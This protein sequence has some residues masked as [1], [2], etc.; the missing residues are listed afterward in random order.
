VR[1]RDELINGR[2]RGAI[3]GRGTDTGE[4]VVEPSEALSLGEESG[5]MVE[6]AVQNAVAACVAE[7][8]EV[9]RVLR[10]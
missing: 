6:A 4:S 10:E 9:V 2:G 8:R 7:E 1:Q 3:G 5:R